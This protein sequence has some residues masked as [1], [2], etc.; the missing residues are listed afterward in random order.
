MHNHTEFKVGPDGNGSYR[1]AFPNGMISVP[2]A[3]AQSATEAARRPQELV[4]DGDLL[5]IQPQSEPT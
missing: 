4:R 3:N 2:F 1:Y 5:R